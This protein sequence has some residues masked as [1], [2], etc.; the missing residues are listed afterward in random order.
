MFVDIG[1]SRF[2]PMGEDERHSMMQRMEQDVPPIARD[3]AL[4]RF[5][6]LL[7]EYVI[8][9]LSGPPDRVDGEVVLEV[10]A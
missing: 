6:A 7:H 4:A 2:R 10:T 9:Y 1:R 3:A 8:P 5:G